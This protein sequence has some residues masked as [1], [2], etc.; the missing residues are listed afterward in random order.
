LL[1]RVDAESLKL[2][3]LP[4]ELEQQV[5]SLFTDWDRVGVPFTQTR[6]LPA[7][8]EGKISL[9]QFLE[10][11]RSWS[12]T[13]QERGKL[14]DKNIAGTL[15]A[16]ERVRLDILQAYADYHLQEVAPRPTHLLDELER[17]L[18]YQR[19]SS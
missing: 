8:L 10:M 17:R 4:L 7:M 12:A 15:T 11:E 2:Y 13:N 18:G 14:I 3:D 5:L 19:R 6:Y 1:V 16:E 9:W